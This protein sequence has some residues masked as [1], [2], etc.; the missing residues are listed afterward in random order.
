MPVIE[1]SF[2][3]DLDSP[4]VNAHIGT[5]GRGLKEFFRDWG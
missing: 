3:D 5:L 4:A 2:S 1:Y